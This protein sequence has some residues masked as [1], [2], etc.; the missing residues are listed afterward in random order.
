MLFS[1]F[2]VLMDR[3]RKVTLCCHVEVCV[4]CTHMGGMG[5]CV[6]MYAYVYVYVCL[7]FM[8]CNFVEATT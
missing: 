4:Y 6:H 3:Q 2:Y 5:A 1:F 7:G 8:L